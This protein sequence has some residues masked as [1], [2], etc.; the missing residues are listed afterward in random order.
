MIF[1]SRA[2]PFAT[3]F[4]FLA[5]AFLLAEP[6][7]AQSQA[8]NGTIRGRIT[9]PGGSAVLDAKVTV[10][11]VDT[12]FRRTVPTEGEGYYV[13]P[14]LPLGTY[15][16]T[17]EK[18]GFSTV[19]HPN[20]ILE[21]GKEAAIDEQLKIGEV[22]TIVEVAGGGPIIEP[23]RINTGRTIDE[24]EIVNLPLTS[25]NPYNL[26]LFQPG[27]SGHPNAELGIPR[28]VNTNGQLDRINYQMDGMVDTQSDRHGL[29]LFPISEV[30]VREVQTV[31]NGYAPE[32]GGTTGN[33][34]NVITNSGT[35]DYHGMF[36][37]IRR[38]VDATARP[39]LLAADKPKPNL[40]LTDYSTN[41]GGRII[42]DKLFFFAGYEHLT[43]GVPTSTTITA[44]NRDKLGLAPA[45][46]AT[47]PSILHGQFV[48][49]RADWNISQRHQMFFRY[50]YF[51][52]NF[53]FNTGVGTLNTLEAATD[54]Q[55]RAHVIGA[56]LIS[57]ISPA[58]LNELRVSW[59]KRD[60]TH[61]PSSTA[62][63]GPQV[64]ILGVAT[65]GAPDTGGDRFREKVPNWNENVTYIRGPHSMKFGASMAAIYD[66][67][68]DVSFARYTFGTIDDYL[69]A[70]SGSN[71][72]A[73]QT[74]ASRTDTSGLSYSSLFWG[75]YAQ[76][77]WQARP[78]LLLT[79]GLR[80]DRYRGP[81]ANSNARYPFSRR[82]TIPNGNIAPRLGMAWRLGTKTVVRASFGK[83]YDASPTN[84]WFNA[85]NLD[86]TNR[87]RNISV[88]S[89]AG[90]AFPAVTFPS[91]APPKPDIVTVTPDYKNAYVLSGTLQATRELSANDALTLGYVHT[92]GRQ[93][94]FL[95]NI[96]LINPIGRLDDGRPIFSDKISSTTRSNPDFNNVTLQDVGA[97]SDYNAMLLT[98]QHRFSHNFQVTASYTYSHT[99]SDAPDVN[100]FEQNLPIEDTTN[101]LRDR[102]N[103]T[104]NR[105]HAFTLSTVFDPKVKVEQRV[106]RY[107]L[108]DNLFAVLG[109]ISSGDQQNVTANKTLNGDSTTGTVTRPLFIGRNT[110]RG[111]S[112]YQ[113]D[114]RYTRT[115]ITLWERVRGQFLVEVNN[116]FN[117]PNI[118]L[119]NTVVKVDD[120][121]KSPCKL[122]EAIGGLPKVFPPKPGV[123][124][125]RIVQFGLALRW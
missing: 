90:P 66:F 65:F 53:P 117:H 44:A 7:A 107:L 77:T 89:G 30:Y 36:Q 60:N 108:N 105:P 64:V 98:Y 76:D 59:A 88:G 84:L 51:R 83:Y 49:G 102:G 23:T 22:A 4:I 112:I 93:L 39:L 94:T 123:L 125:G 31:S 11:N 106:I 24:R 87:T 63:R 52:N 73:Y 1:R 38:S 118:T 85:L 48:N 43:R 116:L 26:I 9:D 13:V 40:A 46:L 28:T 109:N 33:I 120:C 10:I 75:F 115:L 16:V 61:F 25:R 124:E 5:S 42:R 14:N 96:N 58:L 12:G 41:A 34:F 67:Q 19:R 113:I 6:V 37:Y 20:I 18:E 32:F 95:H 101:R 121:K 74:F 29:R 17:V 114:L 50:N 81:D 79:Y 119:L 100:S 99:I 92:A 71:P 110:V 80:Y 27:V 56:Q 47:A 103:S 104:V 62:G 8:I 3:F 68:R 70:K 21:A 86:G 91:T 15:T 78:S 97:N 55:D 82:F 54:F 45:L 122:G 35:N 69:S 2:L 57:T 72:K 111:P